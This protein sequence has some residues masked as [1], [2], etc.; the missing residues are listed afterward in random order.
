M[1]TSDV[2]PIS[3]QLYTL[4]ELAKTDLIGV[5]KRLAGVGYVGVEPFSLY[6]NQAKDVRKALDDLGLVCSSMHMRFPDKSN[7]NEL[8]DI[9]GTLGFD[10]VISGLGADDF[11][12]RDALQRTI[13]RAG[14]AADLVAEKGLRFGYHNHAWEF[15]KVEGQVPYEALLAEVPKMFSQ[16]DIYWAANFGTVDPAAVIRAHAQRIPVLHVKDGTLVRKE[17]NLA[18]GKGKI[19]VP[20]CIHAA[21]ADTLGWL[22]VELDHCATDMFTAVEDSYKYLVGEGLARGNR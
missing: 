5:L 12:T 19:D 4:R 11:K 8:A 17:P 13:N 1:E 16:L 20:A 6:D 2:K 18:V 14:A 3:I 9:A 22:V 21:D 10:M 15:D 7:I